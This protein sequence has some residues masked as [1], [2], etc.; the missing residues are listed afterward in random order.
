MQVPYSIFSFL[1]ILAIINAHF[2]CGYTFSHPQ[3]IDQSSNHTR[4]SPLLSEVNS[5]IDDARN[6]TLVSAQLAA[7]S[8]L[9]LTEWEPQCAN[10]YGRNL[11]PESCEDAIEQVPNTKSRILDTQSQNLQTPVRYSSR[12]SVQ[13][14][15]PSSPRGAKRLT[16]A[17]L[18]F[19]VGQ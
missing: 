10:F 3:R 18:P 19:S 6:I 9:N 14:A 11:D 5:S 1:L 7:D 2:G 4:L 16:I 15:I 8:K 12:K 13:K 17:A